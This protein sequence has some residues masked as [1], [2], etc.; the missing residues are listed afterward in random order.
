MIFILLQGFT[1]QSIPEAIDFFLPFLEYHH[2]MK[3]F[4][5]KVLEP[6]TTAL[7]IAGD[8]EG[9]AFANVYY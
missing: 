3:T 7:I 9:L 2:F 6:K 4:W 5:L 1:L 8:G